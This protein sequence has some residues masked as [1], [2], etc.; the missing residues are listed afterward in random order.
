MQISHLIE[1]YPLFF[2]VTYFVSWEDERDGSREGKLGKPSNAH[3]YYFK[4]EAVN[5][6][7]GILTVRTWKDGVMFI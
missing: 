5:R 6:R 2:P 7:L 1:M 4:R 3:I